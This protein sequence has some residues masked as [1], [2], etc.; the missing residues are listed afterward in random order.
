MKRHLKHPARHLLGCSGP[1]RFH[2]T[3]V[4][5]P[6]PFL[7]FAPGNGA[8]GPFPENIYDFLDPLNLRGGGLFRLLGMDG[9][10]LT[11]FGSPVSFGA[12][13][14][15]LNGT[16]FDGLFQYLLEQQRRA[17]QGFMSLVQG[18]LGGTQGA[19]TP[20][21][22]LQDFEC[23]KPPDGKSERDWLAEKLKGTSFE[24]Y[25]ASMLDS[26][27]H[28]EMVAG[29]TWKIVNFYR[30]TIKNKTGED[31][32]ANL[33]DPKNK[34]R[35]GAIIGH[36]M[37]MVHSEFHNPSGRGVGA[38]SNVIKGN[39]TIEFQGETLTLHG[40]GTK[41]E[42]DQDLASHAGHFNH[43]QTFILNQLTPEQRDKLDKNS[44][45]AVY[46]WDK[47]V[48]GE[49]DLYNTS[50]TGAQTDARIQQFLSSFIHGWKPE[51]TFDPFYIHHIREE[52]GDHDHAHD[53]KESDPCAP[54]PPPDPC[55]FFPF[56]PFFQPPTP[57]FLGSGQRLGF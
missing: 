28:K 3:E 53:K 48:K 54:P 8:F 17:F 36:T 23:A 45:S 14:G 20:K 27:E 38:G 57:W 24:S 44:C 4:H 2:G 16:G 46:F 19:G 30:E 49:T 12:D 11:S 47:G 29:H 13:T 52:H 37:H 21:P 6:S 40:D 18:L 51:D 31:I 5:G 39:I 34:E 43:V 25:V 22:R 33:D 10:N 32:F 26:G 42:T 55:N 35:L 15:G 1:R 7:G 41:E 56:P 9:G 50:Q